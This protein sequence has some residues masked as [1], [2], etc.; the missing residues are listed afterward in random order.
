MAFTKYSD[1]LRQLSYAELDGNFAEM[2]R[3]YD[4][5]LQAR[6]A[7]VLFAGVFGSTTLG[8]AG[9]DNGKYF[10]VPG[11]GAVYLNLY[12]N[13]AGAADFVTSI[14]TFLGG[15]LT[16]ALNE[17]PPVTIASAA[18]VDIGAAA[19]NTIAVSGTAAITSLGTIAAGAIR[20]IRATGAFTLTHN[21]TS[22]ILYDSNIV[23]TVGEVFRF[24]S[25]GAGN[26]RLTGRHYAGPLART[27]VANTFVNGQI[28]SSSDAGAGEV[29]GLRLDRLSATPAAGD[30]GASIRFAFQNSALAFIQNTIIRPKLIDPTA[31]SEDTSFE[32]VCYIAGTP[33]VA[34][35]IGA[36]VQVG[37]PTGGDKGAG[38]LNAVN[39]YVQNSAVLKQS[40]IFVSTDQ[41]I[42]LGGALTLAHG[43]GA[44]PRD[45]K[46][47]LVCQTAELGY[48]IGD[49][50][51]DV[52]ARTIASIVVNAT[53][54]NIRF[55]D[56]ANV[57][58]VHKTTGA[59]S[60]FTAANWKAR[61][62]AIK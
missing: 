33:S 15:T 62:F 48:S 37:T 10:A 13:N 20:Y 12:K 22:L 16:G 61:F 60:A 6:D 18:T 31:G 30:A 34:T 21:A 14:G 25:L 11:T 28:I 3:V 27:D 17:A 4:E 8:L 45:A 41:T 47:A 54:L 39:L 1:V 59:R 40:D 38:T 29:V 26:W 55:F 51:M 53:N 46:L 57:A 32:F 50:L 44:A 36:G 49:V 35:V 23:A 9:S 56:S 42:T 24:E 52:S 58:I 43:L 7:A 5:A 2:D 19:S